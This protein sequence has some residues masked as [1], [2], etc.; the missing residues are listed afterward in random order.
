MKLNR[1]EWAGIAAALVLVAFAAVFAVTQT[2]AY[3]D[4]AGE[5]ISQNVFSELC[6]D[7]LTFFPG[8]DDD[9]NTDPCDLPGMS[10]NPNCNGGSGEVDPDPCDIFDQMGNLPPNCDNGSGNGGGGGGGGTTD[11]CPNEEKDPGVQTSGPCNADDVCP[12]VAGVQTNTSE[13]P[14]GGGDT[15]GNSGGTGG[16]GGGGG[17]GGYLFVATTTATSTGETLGAAT[18]TPA[19]SCDTYLTTFI[20][21]GAQN[22]AEQVKRLQHVLKNFE[23]ATVEENGVYDQATLAAVH[24][25][26]TKYWTEILA[27]WDIK[28]ST[29]YVYLTTRKKVNEIYCG[30]SMIPFTAEEN[31]IIEQSKKPVSV[32]TPEKP[33]ATAAA[34]AKSAQPAK[35]K[36]TSTNATTTATSTP[37]PVSRPWAPVTDFFRRLFNRA[38]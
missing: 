16:S 30:N 29:G 32:M 23:G 4:E 11:V 34:P 2:V 15:N 3:A 14:A 25:F 1:F 10:S 27:P 5:V 12:N 8:C 26:Q 21:F 28:A 19:L 36:A 20:K 33:R 37:A 31:Q 38:R 13:C 6:N 17:G 18:T 24:A 7:G 9:S 22:D 35:A